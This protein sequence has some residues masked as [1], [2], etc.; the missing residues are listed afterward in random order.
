MKSNTFIGILSVF[1]LLGS[2]S[3]SSKYELENVSLEKVAENQD[4][5]SIARES[6]S[7]PERTQADLLSNLKIIKNA[8]CRFKVANVDSITQLMQ[9]LIKRHNGYISDMRFQQNSH[10]LENRCTI[11]L[12][13][14]HF[15]SV[16]FELANYAEFI[17]YKNINSEDVS[18]E[19]VD[20]QAR[21]NTKLRVQARYE[22]ILRNKA[23][24]VEEILQTEEKLR[25]LQEEIEAAQG[26]LHYLSN[27]V[28]LSTIQV[29]LY[30]TVSHVDEPETYI[31]SYGSKMK[32]SLGFGWN[33]LKGILL[34]ILYIWPLLFILIAVLL[35]WRYRRRKSKSIPS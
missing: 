20:L 14:Q 30:E 8:S 25:R 28:A 13:Q 16:L 11:R 6:T 19:Y 31:Q 33:L 5:N 29:D 22:D 9:S 24:T 10:S 18:E 21:L 4:Y 15:E 34:G 7:A 27:K 26:R 35:S 2:C 3:Q 12:P 23:R 17:D 32:E 1:L